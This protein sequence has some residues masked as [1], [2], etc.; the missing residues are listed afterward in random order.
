M[1]TAEELQ[2]DL[3]KALES[4][5]K[6]EA[7]NSELIDREK[8]AKTKAEEAEAAREEAASEAAAKAGDVEAVKKQLEAKHKK[9]LDAITR[10]RDELSNSLKTIRVDNEINSTIASLGIKTEFVPA[11]EALLHRRVEYTDGVATIEGKPITD[12]AKEWSTKEGAVY[13]PAPNNSGAGAMG[14]DGS[15]AT[16]LPIPKS[17]EELT[18]AH[19]AL[20]TSDPASYNAIIAQSPLGDSFKV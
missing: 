9:E 8:Q 4:I 1:K 7:K 19:M 18:A 14:N 16:A 17:P 11:V 15:K 13:R 12:W 3:E 10:E 2:A 6:L 5:K 20:A